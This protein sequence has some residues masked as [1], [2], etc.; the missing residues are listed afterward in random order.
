MKP[1]GSKSYRL[2]IVEDHELT[3]QGLSSALNAYPDL[4]VIASAASV[5]ELFTELGRKR[6]IDLVVLDLRLADGSQPIDNVEKIQELTE[7]IV[8]LVIVGKP[9]F[10]ASGFNYQRGRSAQQSA[11][12]R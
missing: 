8:V 11:A 9:L 2:A 4:E 7:N 12:D 3:R 6:K 1:S 5:P 10:V